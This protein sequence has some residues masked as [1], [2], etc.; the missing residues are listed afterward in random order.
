MV[1]P[2]APHHGILSCNSFQF[3]AGTLH[4]P[5]GCGVIRHDISSNPVQV[6]LIK[7]NLNAFAEC[8]QGIAMV[9]GKLVKFIAGFAA[10]VNMPCNI[11]QA[12][13]ANHMF[14]VGLLVNPE[15]DS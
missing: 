12:Y 1:F 7:S 14:R 15:T 8:F 10:L 4:Q 2:D 11:A 5:Y 9:P 3:K 13:G 6:Q